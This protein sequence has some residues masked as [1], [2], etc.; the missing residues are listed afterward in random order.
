MKKFIFVTGGVVSSLGKGI[1]AASIGMLLRN[2]GFDVSMLKFDPYINVDSGTMNPFQHG[3]VFVTVDGAETDLDLGH[4]ERF[5]DKDTSASNNVT[6]G[7]IYFSVIKKERRGDFLGNT[8]QVVPHITNAIKDSLHYLMKKDAPD[9]L[10]AEVGGT[11]G[12][13]ESQPFLE[14]IRQFRLDFKRTD[15]LYIHL[16]LVPFL[17]TIGEVKTKPT[18]H[19]VNELRRIGIQPDILL[20]RSSVDIGKEVKEKISLFCNVPVDHVIPIPDVTTTYYV[21]IILSKRLIEKRIM[22]LL[23]IKPKDTS[24]KILQNWKVFVKKLIEPKKTIKIGVVGK[25]TNIVDSYK[26]I[27]QSLIHAAAFFNAKAEIKWIESESL[28]K[29]GFEKDLKDIDGILVPG[30]FGMRG[31]E[32]KINA[33]QFARENNLPFLGICLGM[34]AAVI[35]FA[36]NVCK[37]KDANSTE[38]DEKTKFPVIDLQETQKDINSKGGTMRLGSFPCK[39]KKN[40]TAYKLYDTNLILERHRHRYEFNNDYKKDFIENGLLVSGVCPKN[41]LV[42]I[43]ELKDHPFFIGCQ[44]H[45]EFQSRPLTPHPLFVGFAEAMLKKQEV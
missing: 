38:W 41:N 12:D 16:T 14:A 34:Q 2:L 8:V 11:V 21:P 28:E 31:I 6:T 18:Q 30:G 43:V 24:N 10:I 37:L 5:L 45:P 23:D 17:E 40:S 3:E 15:V 20:C 27:T 9:I 13:I 7:K 1:S 33:V 42:E 35:E 4:Y 39:L 29:D 19:S 22:K 26:S 25:Y 44:F 36:R 32:G